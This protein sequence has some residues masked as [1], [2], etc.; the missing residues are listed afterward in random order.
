MLAT[1]VEP[2]TDWIDLP[3]FET[4]PNITVEMTSDS[5]EIQGF[6]HDIVQDFM[7]CSPSELYAIA[8]AIKAEV[9][10]GEPPRL[11]IIQIRTHNK[12]YI[13]KVRCIISF[14]H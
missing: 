1:D 3:P 2:V 6:A 10:P 13:F 9:R 11:D 12:V 8:L 7:R 5:V 14:L 4:V